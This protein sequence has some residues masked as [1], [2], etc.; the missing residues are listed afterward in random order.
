MFFQVKTEWQFDDRNIEIRRFNSYTVSNTF[1][2]TCLPLILAH[3]RPLEVIFAAM[4]NQF[5][6]DQNWG[7]YHS[8]LFGEKEIDSVIK[9]AFKQMVTYYLPERNYTDSHLDQLMA[10]YEEVYEAVYSQMA[11]ERIMEYYV[12]RKITFLRDFSLLTGL[13]IDMNVIVSRIDKMTANSKRDP[14]AE[15][16]GIDK[17]I[18]VRAKAET[19]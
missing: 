9:T 6:P 13:N 1:R 16:K 10:D 2:D 19:H 3:L 18:N 15:L 14:D 8:V 7:L 11:V 17:D 5:A 4:I 12:K